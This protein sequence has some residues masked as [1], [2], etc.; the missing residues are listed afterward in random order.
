VTAVIAPAQIVQPAQPDLP[1]DTTALVAKLQAARG[2]N[3]AQ[4]RQDIEEVLQQLQ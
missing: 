1:Q 2:K 3:K 4:M